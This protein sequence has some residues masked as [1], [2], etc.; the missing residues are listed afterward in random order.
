MKP[1]E[2][3][4]LLAVRQKLS[5]IEA[6]LGKKMQREM[7]SLPEKYG[8]DG[9]ESFIAA[10][11]ELSGGVGSAGSAAKGKA[12]GKRKRGK[13]TEEIRQKVKELFEAEKTGAE[14]AAAVGLS[15]PTVQGIK[16]KLKMVK[17]RRR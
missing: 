12:K 7:A 9:M 8:Y 11:Q 6:K 13:V 15:L 17:E 10:L 3:K 4:K 2:L 5:A 14:V 1:T 16:K